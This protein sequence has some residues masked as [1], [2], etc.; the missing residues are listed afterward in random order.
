VPVRQPAELPG[1]KHKR[2]YD[3]DPPPPPDW[4]ITCLFVDKK[5]R[6]Q[7]IE[8]MPGIALEGQVSSLWSN[9]V[10]GIKHMPVRLAAA[11]NGWWAG[12]IWRSKHPDL[13]CDTASRSRL[14][15]VSSE[16]NR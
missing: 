15:K 4:R 7:G 9:F 12:R 16:A 14:L 11:D 10:N 13:Y 8:R 1:I 3:K 2:E 6:G 5:H